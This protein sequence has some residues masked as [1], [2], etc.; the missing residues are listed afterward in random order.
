MQ[1]NVVDQHISHIPA[2]NSKW[3]NVLAAA[4]FCVLLVTLLACLPAMA[5]SPGPDFVTVQARE[6]VQRLVAYGQV[7]PIAT[8][9]V[10]APEAGAVAGLQV[11]PGDHVRAGETLAHLSGPAISSLVLEGEAD[12]RSAQAQLTSAEKSLAIDREQ[13]AAHLAT[14]Q[15]VQQ[16]ESTEAQAR[17]ALDNAQSRLNA[18][19]QMMTIAAPAA[20]VVLNLIRPNGALVATGE[21][22]LTLQASRDLWLRAT[23]YGSD[24]G[25]IHVGMRGS[26]APS[27]GGEA[28]PVRVVSIPGT[29][30]AGGGESI[31]L[32]PI[33]SRFR[34]NG[35]AGKLALRL[36]PR[37]MVEVPTRSLILSQGQWW[38]LVHTTG[39]NHP[40]QVIPGPAEGWNT[41]IE[42]GLAAGT[43][44]VVRNAYLLF[45]EGIGKR[46]QMPD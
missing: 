9:P 32:E 42:S 19:R 7:E 44:V 16:A 46:Y 20:G 39:G 40:Q 29:L 8:V 41:W 15:A 36:P 24:L 23:Y 25:R 27:R 31:A 34:L 4:V 13:L 1:R 21:T 33:G 10:D 26:F 14:R 45:H 18:V 17:V 22:I 28:I 12:V 35:E 6:F 3:R 43:E 37:A 38:V 11:R 5:Q 2:R 30:I